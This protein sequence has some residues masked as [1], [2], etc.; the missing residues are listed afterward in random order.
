[1]I[2]LDIESAYRFIENIQRMS[3][4]RMKIERCLW[5]KLAPMAHISFLTV[6]REHQRDMRLFVE[7]RENGEMFFADRFGQREGGQDCLLNEPEKLFGIALA[8]ISHCL[9]A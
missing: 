6:A 5:R 4:A 7:M 8:F 1:M 2:Q 3:F 9:S